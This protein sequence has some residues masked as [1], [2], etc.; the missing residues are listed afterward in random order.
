MSRAAESATAD[1][2]RR[3]IKELALL[4]LAVLLQGRKIRVEGH[5]DSQGSS[6]YNLDLSQSRADSVRLYLIEQ[7]IAG[8]RMR[9]RGFGEEQPIDSN[10]TA[11]GRAANRREPTTRWSSGSACA[12]RSSPAGWKPAERTKSGCTARK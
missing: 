4:A 5:T 11:D 3:V 2:R 7:G 6:S 10:E 12:P 8:D 9:A 1:D